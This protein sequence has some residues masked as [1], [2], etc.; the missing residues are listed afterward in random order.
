ML[1]WPARA[2][3]DV[4]ATTAQMD[5]EEDEYLHQPRHRPYFLREEVAGPQHRR[6]PPEEVVPSALTA[7]RPRIDTVLFEDGDDRRATDLADPAI[8]AM[9]ATH[10]PL[11]FSLNRAVTR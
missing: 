2:A 4:D 5:D 6:V 7:T 8:S 9:T 1:V 10:Y 11:L 3:A